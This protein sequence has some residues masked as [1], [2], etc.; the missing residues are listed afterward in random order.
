MVQEKGSRR[1]VST[2]GQQ[3]SSSLL[4]YSFGERS[5]IPFLDLSEWYIDHYSQ[6]GCA[7]KVLWLF[8][9]HHIH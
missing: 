8:L 7:A 2:L 3:T 5:H 1:E 6:M 9:I 4:M